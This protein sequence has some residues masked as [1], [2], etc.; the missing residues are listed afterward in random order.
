M[1]P[2]SVGDS[3][4]DG[5]AWQGDAALCDV[6]QCVGDDGK[7]IWIAVAETPNG[8]ARKQRV[9]LH[10][11]E[12]LLNIDLLVINVKEFLS[13]DRGAELQDE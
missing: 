3:F 10:Y 4:K 1:V 2:C 7:E 12:N 8:I 6:G 11:V 5:I 9:N 13:F